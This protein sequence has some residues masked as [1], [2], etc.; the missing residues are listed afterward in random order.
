LLHINFPFYN[1]E[2]VWNVVGNISKIEYP[3]SEFGIQVLVILS[4]DSVVG[5]A[6][7]IQGLQETGPLILKHIR[8]PKKIFFFRNPQGGFL[9]KAPPEL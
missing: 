9:I 7:R 4:D 3:K 5:Y 6:K 1:E 2:Y 8:K